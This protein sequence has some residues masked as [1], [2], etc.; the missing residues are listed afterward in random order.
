MAV[1]RGLVRETSTDAPPLALLLVFDFV[2]NLGDELEKLVDF[3]FQVGYAIGRARR[4][5]SAWPKACEA[6][7]TLGRARSAARTKTKSTLRTRA[8]AAIES[9]LEVG[10]RTARAR[11]A[12]TRR[13]VFARTMRWPARW[14]Q[15]RTAVSKVVRPVRAM[16][17]VR[18]VIGMVPVM[19]AVVGELSRSVMAVRRSM[20][21]V[22]SKVV[23]AMVPV[24]G[25]VPMVTAV[26]CEF[27]R[28]VMA[29][30]RSMMS[31]IG[32]A[33]RPVVGMV[34]VMIAVVGE[35]SRSVMAVQWSTMSVMGIVVRSVM[36][37]VGMM[38]VMTMMSAVVG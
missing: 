14:A 32:K 33:L 22:M 18:P 36:P 15:R 13:G 4:S 20:M 29:V 11:L 24:I 3:L 7:R 5:C 9:V 21:A 1:G 25:V 34:P 10:A 12:V 30:R 16:M 6:A 2:A 31:V 23:R 8:R 27:S 26:V 17:R 28:S 37:V 38:C 35:L 19:I